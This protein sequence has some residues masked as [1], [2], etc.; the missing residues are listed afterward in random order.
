[1]KD[2]L[3]EI[4]RRFRLAMNGV[5]SA[6]MRG[7]GMD[8]KVNFG[9]SFSQLK[10][11][12][13]SYVPDG[14]LAAAL[15][16]EDIRESRLLATFLQPRDGFGK[17][18]ALRWMSEADKP[19]LADALCMNL[20]QYL[21][22]AP[23]LSAG[24]ITKKDLPSKRVGYALAGRLFS[25]RIVFQKEYWLLFEKQA[26]E[27]VVSGNG[28]LAA[29]ALD[30]LKKAIRCNSETA[31]RLLE[32]FK[33]NPLVYEELRFEYDYYSCRFPDLKE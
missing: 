28:M 17:E 2:L 24:F 5:A 33:D 20:L 23:E 3:N 11:I 32:L 27:D 14:E 22:F 30:A 21:P 9:V 15:W 7:K 12:A 16:K 10:D 29:L 6:S 31:L 4:H 8:Y 25:G 1:M 26:Q 18:E 19:E 13:S